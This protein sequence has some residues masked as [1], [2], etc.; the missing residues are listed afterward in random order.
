MANETACIVLLRGDACFSVKANSA[1][2]DEHA[3][4]LGNSTGN[5]DF[6][7]VAKF[8]LSEVIGVW[9]DS[10]VKPIPPPQTI[11]RG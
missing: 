11:S 3:I 4:T 8:P 1:I 7:F 5:G 10:E 6:S 2:H 9:I